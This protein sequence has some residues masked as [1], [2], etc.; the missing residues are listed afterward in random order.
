MIGEKKKGKKEKHSF[1]YISISSVKFLAYK[2]WAN[3]FL[4]FWLSPQLFNGHV[5]FFIQRDR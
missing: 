4:S 5:G 3:L 2:R 1:S